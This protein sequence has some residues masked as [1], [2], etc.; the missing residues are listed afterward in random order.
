MD[1]IFYLQVT[2]AILL[3]NFWINKYCRMRIAVAKAESEG[4]KPKLFGQD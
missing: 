2:G 1:W 3:A 4:K